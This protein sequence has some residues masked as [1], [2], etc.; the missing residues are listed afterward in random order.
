MSEIKVIKKQPQVESRILNAP[1]PFKQF[2][3]VRVAGRNCQRFRSWYDTFAEAEQVATE[4]ASSEESGH[5]LYFVMESQLAVGYSDTF[6]RKIPD[7]QRNNFREVK[8]RAAIHQTGLT[9]EQTE[10]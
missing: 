1:S 9:A 2:A 7:I 5:G 10:V 8:R 4:Y 6:E 3:V